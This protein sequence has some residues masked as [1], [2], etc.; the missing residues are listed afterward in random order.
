MLGYI[1]YTLEVFTASYPSSSRKK[2]GGGKK[3]R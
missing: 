1:P 2:T 3:R